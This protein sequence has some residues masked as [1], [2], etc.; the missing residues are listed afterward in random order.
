MITVWKQRR[1]IPCAFSNGGKKEM[2]KKHD[3]SSLPRCPHSSQPNCLPFQLPLFILLPSDLS[4]VQ[5]S[6]SSYL[7]NKQGFS[8]C[9]EL[10]T[11]VIV[12]S[13]TPESSKRN[14]KIASRKQGDAAIPGVPRCSEEEN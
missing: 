14:K 6:K 12:S 7:F 3:T 1:G 4:A 9:S 2:W 8:F 13:K 10:G 5:T 11:Y